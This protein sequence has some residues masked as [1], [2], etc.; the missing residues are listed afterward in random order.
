MRRLDRLHLEFRFAGSRML[1]DLLAAEGARSAAGMLK[2]RF[3]GS[4]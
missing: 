2:R 3:G 4:G 1:R